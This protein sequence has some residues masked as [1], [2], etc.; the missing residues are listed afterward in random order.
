MELSIITINYNNKAGLQKTIDSVICQTWKDYEWIVIDGGST[1]GSRELIEQYQ[2]YFS[3]W[4]SEADN[5][6]YNAMNKGIAK[7]NGDYLNF[8]N[9]GDMFYDKTVLECIF[10]NSRGG[11]IIYGDWLKDYTTHEEIVSIPVNKLWSTL[12]RQNIC[13]QTM[14]VKTE[15]LKQKGFDDSMFII[16]DWK[17]LV[18]LLLSGATI[19]YIPHTVC[20]YDMNGISSKIEDPQ[21]EIEY[22]NIQS[23]YPHYLM[24]ALKELYQ[25]N[26]NDY[27]QI[28]LSLTKERNIGSLITKSI[29]KILCY[30]RN[31]VYRKNS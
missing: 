29:L 7:A 31:N 16:A 21:I 30:L 19:E 1:D 26:N 25:Y 14:F 20:R 28:V 24:D 2:Q 23:L 18:E 3:C 27:V 12:W 5:G 13:Q 4:C 15:L 6:I 8:M 11:D 10:G 22:H 17:R 9:S